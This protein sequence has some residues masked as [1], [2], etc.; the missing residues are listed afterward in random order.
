MAST[1]DKTKPVD[2]SLVTAAE[3]RANFVAASTDIETLQAN[4]GATAGLLSKSLDYTTILTDANK[5]ILH[6]SSDTSARIFTI[7]ANS[8]VAYPLGTTLTFLNQD[9]AGSLTIAIASDTMRL[10]GAGTT[11]SRTLAH[12]GIAI[13]IKLATTEWLIYGFGLT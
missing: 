1:I 2:N 6:P 11:G 4:Q 5:Q 3:L 13:A 9:S 12:N 10:A 7:A 8:S